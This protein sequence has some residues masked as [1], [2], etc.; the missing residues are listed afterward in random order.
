MFSFST[1]L[2]DTIASFSSSIS[3]LWHPIRLLA[4]VKA[5]LLPKVDTIHVW[6]LHLFGRTVTE[7]YIA[8]P[9][10]SNYAAPG[11][12]NPNTGLSSLISG[13]GQSYP[14]PPTGPGFTSQQ[15]YPP[16][17]SQFSSQASFPPPPPP[18][19]QYATDNH[20]TSIQPPLQSPG[21]N[22][23]SEKTFEASVD[24]KPPSGPV[25]GHPSYTQPSATAE[26]ESSQM[27][28]GAPS[29]AHF[30]GVS[31]TQDDVGTFNG[32]S[33][34]ISHRDSNTILTLQ[35]AK[36]CPLHAKPGRMRFAG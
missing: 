11:K 23:P 28:G 12:L 24:P 34:R 19:Q 31:A 7:L 4:T 5:P 1:V 14:P 29:A 33:Y 3:A 32:G 21:L 35:L 10:G 13:Q 26:K 6:A 30:V 17:P 25:A 2:F 36:L 20:R 22:R 15:S 8:P 9:N 16:P 27:P 18:Q